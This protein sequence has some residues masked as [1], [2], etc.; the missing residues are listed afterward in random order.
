MPSQTVMAPSAV[1]AGSKPTGFPN[2]P[3]MPDISSWKSLPVSRYPF[4][5]HPPPTDSPEVKQ[6]ISEVAASGIGIPD[7]APFKEGDA[8]TGMCDVPEN[9][10]RIG[11]DTECWWTCGHCARATDITTCNEKLTWG[12]SFDDGPAPYTPDLLQFLGGKKLTT[13]FFVVGSRVVDKPDYLQA[14][15]AAGHQIAVHTWSHWSLTTQT[16]EEI[17]AELGWSKKIIKDAIGVTPKYMRPPFGD[18]DDRVRA[19]SMAMGLTPIIWTTPSQ[20]ESFDTF[21]WS[22]Q[23]GSQTAEGALAKF[24]AMLDSAT[25]IDTGFIVLEHDIFESEV[26][27][28]MGYFLPAALAHKPAFKIQSIRECIGMPVADVYAETASSKALAPGNGVGGK[29]T[30]GAPFSNSSSN[31]QSDG[32]GGN[33]GGSQ[34]GNGGTDTGTGGALLRYPNVG[35]FAF[36]VAFVGFIL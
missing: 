18:I 34:G 35:P 16:T 24:N 30:S 4:L 2:A 32:Q 28:A 11:N 20:T 13:T 7:I 6:W 26:S 5:D 29:V 3:A 10:A 27:L 33:T 1:A 22:V 23:E 31:S 25:K 17:I 36:L 12:S 9:K 19:I 8:N 15:Y 14:M 21:D